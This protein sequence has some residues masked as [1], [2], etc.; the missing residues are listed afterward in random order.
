MR[1]M[2]KRIKYNCNKLVKKIKLFLEIKEKTK[3]KKENL[4]KTKF[5]IKI[6]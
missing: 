6:Q 1:E 4:K 5:I 2:F 3:K